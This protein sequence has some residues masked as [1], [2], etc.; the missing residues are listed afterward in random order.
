MDVLEAA[1]GTM[2]LADLAAAVGVNRPRDLTRRKN[3]QTGKGRDGFVTRLADVGVLEVDGDTVSLCE[4]WLEALDRERDRTG[5]IALYRRD[6]ARYN[7]ER[8]GWRLRHKV[9]VDPAPSEEEM[10]EAREG[11]PE[12][13]RAAI[14]ASIAR[15][16]QDRPEYRGRRAGQITCRLMFYLP[17]DFPRGS[18]GAPKDAEVEAILEGVAA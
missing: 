5:E 3:L 4:N 14:E 11:Y 17:D 1:G 16:F 18:D 9:K 15:L 10:R 8:D 13:R 12:R 2:T 7:R 6:M